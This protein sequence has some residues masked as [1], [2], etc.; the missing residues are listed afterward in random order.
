MN[1]AFGFLLKKIKDG[2]FRYF[3]AYENNTLLDWYKLVCTKDFLAKLKDF[4]SKTDVIE[5]CSRKK[6]NTKRRFYRLTNLPVFAASLKDVPIGCTNAVL[7]EL[8]L[9]NCAITSL[10]YEENTRHPSDD[11]LC[12]FAAIALILQGNCKLSE[13]FSKI[14]ISFINILDGFSLNQFK[15]V[16]TN[17]IP[18]N[19]DMVKLN[20]LLYD[21]HITDGNIIGETWGQNVQ[22]NEKAVERQ[23]YKKNIC[24]VSNK[25]AV[26]HPFAALI[27][28]VCQSTFNLERHLTTCSERVKNVY[29]R[30]A[31]Q[32]PETL[33]YKLD[34]FGFR[35][36]SQQKLFIF[37][38]F[39]TSNP[40]VS[41]KRPSNTQAQQ[42]GWGNKFR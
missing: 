20:T 6:M 30:N 26:F 40:F 39:S 13:E 22:K 34:S 9:K 29:H 19:E 36:T 27:V 41:K 8:L 15:G 12:L 28:T 32:I 21:L 24:C 23:R 5:T 4:R 38:Q 3:Y 25:T 35:Y 17:D 14:F 2:V 16:H 33:F 10:L 11:S 31:Y 37:K 42:H 18:T 7:Y 1:L